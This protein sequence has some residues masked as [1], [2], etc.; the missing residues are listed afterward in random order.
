MCKAELLKQ[1]G[2]IGYTTALS[3]QLGA[4]CGSQGDCHRQ[5]GEPEVAQGCYESGVQHLLQA[6]QPQDAEVGNA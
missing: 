4:V 2:M 3:S 1:V 6:S 5:L